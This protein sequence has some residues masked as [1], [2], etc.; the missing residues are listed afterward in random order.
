MKEETANGITAVHSDDGR[1]LLR[2]GRETRADEQDATLIHVRDF[3]NDIYY[4]DSR[5]DLRIP[6]GFTRQLIARQPHVEAEVEM[7][8]TTKLAPEDSL[9]AL[10]SAATAPSPEL[11]YP[12]EFTRKRFIRQ[13]PLT[14]HTVLLG[15]VAERAELPSRLTTVGWTLP[16]EWWELAKLVD[17]QWVLPTAEEL[18]TDP[19]ETWGQAIA[20]LHPEE[21]AHDRAIRGFIMYGVPSDGLA[22]Q[23]YPG[24]GKR[25]HTV[26]G[27]LGC[28]GRQVVDSFGRKLAAEYRKLSLDIVGLDHKLTIHFGWM[29]MP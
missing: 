13:H 17:G 22:R 9:K 10:I 15:D 20:F 2:H 23:T 27:P 16:P 6:Q 1:L 18:S 12:R 14:N 3:R 21:S 7:R 25:T 19:Q 26:G 28:L 8:W 11:D 29:W 24:D 5:D 4:P